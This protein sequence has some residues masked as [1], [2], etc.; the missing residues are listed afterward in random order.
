[1]LQGMRYL[2][3]L[4]GINVGGNKIVRMADLKKAFENL[5]Y[6]DVSTYINSGNVIF[7]S[8]RKPNTATIE[9]ALTK[10][11]GFEIRIVIRDAKNIAHVAAALPDDWQNDVEQKTD[12]LFLWDAFDSKKSLALI[13]VNDQIDTLCYV[14]GAILWHVQRKDYGKS[15]MHD[16]VGTPIYKNMTARNSNTLRKLASL[17]TAPP[18]QR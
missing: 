16:F 6:A 12:I 14:P 1:M 5:G 4:R 9:A 18:A 17:L 15:G 3:L 7:T 2:A 8:L 13:K 11:F 10:T